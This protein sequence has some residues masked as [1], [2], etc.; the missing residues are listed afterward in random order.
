MATPLTSADLQ[1]RRRALVHA[2]TDIDAFSRCI[3]RRPLRR[4]QLA[5][6]RAI[7][8]SALRGRGLTIAVMMPRQAGKN[9]TAAQ[10]EALLLNLHRRRGGTIVKAA[11]TFTP[12]ALNSLQRL[13]DGA[14]RV[15]AGRLAAWGPVREQGYLLRVGQARAA[16]FSANAA[17]SVVGATANILL[18]GDEAQDIDEAKWDKDF[19]PMAASTARHHGAVG[20]RLDRPH[21]AGPRHPRPARA[22]SSATACSASL[23]SPG[24]RWPPRCPPINSYVRGEIARLGSDHPLIK[25]PIPAARDR[26]GGR[27]V[28]RA[29]RRR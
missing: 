24:S 20:H 25:H 29:R 21:P 18:E 22:W 16:F 4:Y 12:Q 10:V 2:L 28:A 5:P 6:A 7:V 9:E 23:P 17:A 14:G 3:L 1:R 13:R 15:D 27:P 8:R 11:P 26:R 19:R